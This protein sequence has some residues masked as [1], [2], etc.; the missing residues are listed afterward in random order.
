MATTI[1][2]Y[3]KIGYYSDEFSVRNDANVQ[4]MI[5]NC[6]AT[7]YDGI[8]F[9]LTVPIATD[10]GL[11]SSL[12]FEHM[13][14]LARQLQSQ[15]I[16][17]GVLLN[18]NFNGGNASYVGQEALGQLRPAEFSMDKMLNSMDQFLQ[19]MAPTAQASGM[20][21]MLIASN[22]P[23]Y[24]AND[25]FSRWQSTL[26]A[27]RQIYKGK[28]SLAV[29]SDDKF[30]GQMWPLISI[31]NLL[32][33]A[34]LVARPYISEKPLTDPEEILSGFYQ[35]KLDAGSFV[36]EVISLATQ[37]GKPVDLIF[38]AM[39]LPNAF[40]T[41]WDPTVAQ[42]L[43]NPLPVRSDLQVLAY[44]AFL[45]VVSQNL[46]KFVNTISLG[47]YEP[48]SI[49]MNLSTPP[50]P[51]VDPGDWALWNAFKY[52]DSSLFP[53][54]LHDVLSKYFKGTWGGLVQETTYGS[55]GNDLI[56]TH[57]AKQ[58]VWL[59]GGIDQCFG[60][61]GQEKYVVSPKVKEAKLTVS[62]NFWQHTTDDLKASVDV[63]QNG[64]TLAT[65][66]ASILFSKFKVDTWSEV[67]VVELVLPDISQ[68]TEVVLKFSGSSGFA[69]IT[70]M[71][72][73][74]KP[75]NIH[76]GVTS[77]GERP[78]WAQDNWLIAGQGLRFDAAKALDTTAANQ[79]VIDGG[80]GID[81]IQMNSAR[82]ASSFVISHQ[83]DVWMLMDPSRLYDT[84]QTKNVERLI[85]SDLGLALDL[86]ATAGQ[87]AKI[88]GAVF[89]KSAVANREY[90]GIGLHFLDDLNFNYI[91]LMQLAISARLG[92][93]PSNA[94]VVDLL[95]TNVVGTSPDAAT[96]KS[97]TDLLDNHSLNPTNL[98]VLAADTEMNKANINLVGLIQTGLQ[99][100][101][102][103]G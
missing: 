14:S 71:K 20:D 100:L 12:H 46:W 11:Q 1:N 52:F 22:Q 36:N 24:F 4:N 95:Y 33:E 73:N 91:D 7:G 83:Q 84:I 5:N 29:N 25:Y 64:V 44:E 47:N 68:S 26:T 57:Q 38:N 102:F 78:A 66:P 48:W 8:L 30:A 27:V 40:D 10:G 99:Y 28:L 76:Q 50:G 41:G 75:L 3:A 59:M 32:D 98:G 6:L 51:G 34:T 53:A 37:T 70:D 9:E 45:Q 89:G 54:Q 42:A 49:D 61:S 79:S 23:D 65:I 16:K 97:F 62:L 2:N 35:S 86:N 72:V 96:R 77:L 101:P 74:G 63:T 90:V 56:Y 69:A 13:F 31:W 17:T 58:S 18:W 93:S 43:Q 103:S 60:G 88:L 85:F 15:G 80:D 39:A 19:T 87:L 21:L 67:Q 82:T 94:Q 55:S 81:T 92:V